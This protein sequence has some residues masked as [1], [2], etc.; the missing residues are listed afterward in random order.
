MSYI[1]PGDFHVFTESERQR[2]RKLCDA[3]KD[4]AQ[5]KALFTLITMTGLRISEALSLN[6]GDI[7]DERGMFDQFTVAREHT[8]GK[9]AA[10]QLSL[11]DKHGTLQKILRVW[12]MERRRS[13]RY[14][15]SDP[16][17]ISRTGRRLHRKLAWELWHNIMVQ[18]EVFDLINSEKHYPHPHDGRHTRATLLI[19]QTGDLSLAQAALGHARLDHLKIYTHRRVDDLHR[20][21]LSMSA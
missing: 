11:L 14:A 9:R 16:L 13:G 8:K 19:E 4:G 21:N 12:L 17:F 2:I 7:E 15:L 1:T 18:A 20:A 5:F 10:R 3:R 6:I